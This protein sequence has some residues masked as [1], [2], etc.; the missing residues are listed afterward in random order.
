[1]SDLPGRQGD[2]IYIP[3]AQ[4]PDDVSLRIAKRD[5]KGRI[6]LAEGETTGHAHAILDDAATLFYQP[7][8]DEMADRF[9]RVEAE[10]ALVHE[11]HGNHQLP[12]GD[13]I[14]RIKRQYTPARAVRVYD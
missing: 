2:V 5:A 1:M 8:L 14:V 6:V 7:D 4:I 3:I 10:V 13:Y 9:L 11:E 12:R